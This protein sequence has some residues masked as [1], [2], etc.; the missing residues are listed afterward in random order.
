M[1]VHA[2]KNCIQENFD[3]DAILDGKPANLRPFRILMS[4]LDKPEVGAVI[5]EDVLVE[6]LSGVCIGSASFI[7][8]LTIGGHRAQREYALQPNQ[9]VQWA[10]AEVSGGEN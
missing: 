6:N 4:F 3:N 9:H 10:E 8:G 5:L 2:V 1:L 7:V